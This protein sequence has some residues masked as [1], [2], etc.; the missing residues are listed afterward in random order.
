MKKSLF[1]QKKSYPKQKKR[2]RVVVRNADEQVLTHKRNPYKKPDTASQR[3][4][5]NIVFLCMSLLLLLG[6]LVYHPF[7]RITSIETTGLERVNEDEFHQTV[8]GIMQYK[9]FFVIPGNNYFFVHMQELHDI[10]ETKFP[11]NTIRVEKKFPH[12]LTIT[13]QEKVSTLI[14]DTG[15][16]YSY[17]GDDGHIV[18]VVRHVGNDEWNRVTEEVTSTDAFGAVQT[19]IKIVSE[20]HTPP[21]MR[22]HSEMGKYPIVYDRLRQEDAKEGMLVLEQGTVTTIQDWF[23]FV[24]KQLTIPLH[25]IE[26]ENRVGD[27]ILY[28]KAGW[29][30]KI[31][32]DKPSDIQQ[33]ALKAVLDKRGS[34]DGLSYVDVR[35]GD[36]IYWK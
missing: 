6:V 10:L 24:E 1:P 3:Q 7:F 23:A 18:E 11:L 31:Q 34:S 5:R 21:L 15:K 22:L 14:Y 20:S 30:I 4:K 17:V 25:Y 27:A 19:E 36:R 33:L 28:T 29:Y 26:L 12:Y 13:A 9:R 32:L 8:H 2:Y 35:F 16:H